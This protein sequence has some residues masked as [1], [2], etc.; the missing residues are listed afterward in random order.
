MLTSRE[1]D[2]IFDELHALD[3]AESTAIKSA[4][5]SMDKC[6]ASLDRLINMLKGDNDD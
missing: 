5:V 3:E 2:D 1:I 4:L 6:I